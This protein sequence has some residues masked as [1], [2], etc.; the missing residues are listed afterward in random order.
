MVLSPPKRHGGHGSPLV[1]SR[2]GARGRNLRSF[3]QE[4][5]SAIL[6]AVG[7][8]PTACVAKDD[9]VPSKKRVAVWRH[10]ELFANDIASRPGV[11]G[12]HFHL[13]EVPIAQTLDETSKASG[14]AAGKKA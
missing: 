2:P 1:V 3:R 7:A 6:L 14:R 13:D 5:S 4:L 10:F 9:T 11:A 8:I 12:V